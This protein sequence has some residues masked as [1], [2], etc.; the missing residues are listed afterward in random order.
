MDEEEVYEIWVNRVVTRLEKGDWKGEAGL[1]KY[2]IH[3]ALEIEN[4]HITSEWLA[5]M[6]TLVDIAKRLS[7]Y[8]VDIT[9]NKFFFDEEE[10]NSEKK[11][12]DEVILHA[13]K[14]KG[15]KITGYHFFEWFVTMT[16]LLD[17]AVRLTGQGITKRLQLERLYLHLKEDMANMEPPPF[18][19]W[20]LEKNV[21]S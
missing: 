7:G 13:T 2:M 3:R 14:L 15:V 4:C 10:W 20:L 11:L 8:D 19:V 12:R 6:S 21:D 5:S 1:R 17:T 9:I 16:M 18:D